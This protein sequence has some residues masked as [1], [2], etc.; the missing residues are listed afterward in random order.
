M[1]R[2]I[3]FAVMTAVL[4]QSIPA[5]P[6]TAA[7]IPFPD[8]ENSWFVYRQSISYLKKKNAISGYAD[9]TF[10]PKALVNRAEFLKLVFAARGAPEPIHADCFLDVKADDWYA[11]FVCAAKRRGI[12]EGYPSGTGAVFRPE[13]S[14]VYSEAM[15]MVLE[16]YGREVRP[17]AGGAW[18]DAYAAPL[19]DDGI[20]NRN[21]FIPW[22][23]LTR[24]RAADLIAKFVKFEEDKKNP[25]RSAGCGLA[26]GI[27]PNGVH[28]N[29]VDREFLLTIPP[30]YDPQ[31]A[32]PLIV[33]FH[34][35]TNSNAQVRAYYGFDRAAKNAFI[36]Y[37][38]AIKNQSGTF[39]WSVP[40]DLT[41]DLGDVAFFDALVES[42]SNSYCIDMNSI[43]VAGHSL[44]AWMANS[45]A[46]V[47]GDVV[48][49]SGTVGG[50]SVLR[51]CAGPSAMMMINNP[52]DASSPFATAEKVRDQRIRENACLTQ[53]KPVEPA[54]LLCR[55][56]AGCEGGNTVVWCPHEIDTDE[57]NRYYPHNW[58]REAGKTIVEFFRSLK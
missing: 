29:G 44:G 43:F 25:N 20:L 34:G 27:P 14:V 45:I 22:E 52:H 41:K 24:E 10:K 1:R 58:P 57:H 7:E 38:A 35:R 12:V 21:A 30:Q 11:P 33:A 46:C 15:K 5:L 51:D 54:S 2:A 16:A 8:T 32:A 3:S 37:P 42:I 49:G 18:Y 4:W 47:R 48:R 6:A 50:D 40:G 13:Q 28:V 39:S 17:S 53:T 36:V 31:T 56:Y 26:P 55:E 19:D 23:P 9:G